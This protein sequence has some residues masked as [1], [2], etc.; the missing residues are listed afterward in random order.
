[1]VSPLCSKLFTISIDYRHILREYVICER[2][3]KK[4]DKK[5]K[6]KGNTENKKEKKGTASK[7]NSANGMHEI[8]DLLFTV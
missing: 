8:C 4:G 2:R 5:E 6:K 7:D 1:M 3:G